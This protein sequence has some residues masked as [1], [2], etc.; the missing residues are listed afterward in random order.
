M[1]RQ[2]NETYKIGRVPCGTENAPP[3]GRFVHRTRVGGH[4]NEVRLSRRLEP[5]N[6]SP[7]E[8]HL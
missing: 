7:G 2:Q 5:D 3:V 6:W 8:E 1:T 4:L